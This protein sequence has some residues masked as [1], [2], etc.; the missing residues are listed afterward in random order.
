MPERVRF[1]VVLSLLLLAFG[2]SVR[3]AAAQTK[4]ELLTGDALK[5]VVPAGFYFAGQSAETQMRNSAAAEIAPNR[6]VVAGL[7][8]TSGYST[9]ISGKY[10]G[11]LITDSP[12]RIGNKKLGTGAYGFGFAADGTLNI[13]DLSAK[14]ILSVAG[15]TDGDMRRPRPLMMTVDGKTVRFYKGRTYVAIS[16]R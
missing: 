3:P 6:F 15:K 12:L 13:F 4:P 16:P 8:D 7:V 1:V 9:D 2:L 10:E 5:R 14:Q 11:F